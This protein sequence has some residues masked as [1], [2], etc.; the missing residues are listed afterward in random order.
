MCSMC[1]CVQV[2]E[3]VESLCSERV[4]TS[5]WVHGVPID[6]VKDLGQAVRDV[7]GASLLRL[8]L[9]VW[10]TSPRPVVQVPS[11]HL[12]VHFL[13]PTCSCGSCHPPR[14]VALPPC[15]PCCAVMYGCV[16]L[17]GDAIDRLPVHQALVPAPTLC[18][19]AVLCCMC[20]ASSR[21]PQH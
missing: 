17:T 11:A 18:L 3:V 16:R 21:S 7:V 1:Q 4:L 12:L 20:C 19:V 14:P 9:Q 8:T 13:L 6:R 10:P 2:P 5:T 15:V